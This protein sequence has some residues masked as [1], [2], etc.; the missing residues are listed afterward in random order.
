MNLFLRFALFTLLLIGAV[1][2]SF[3]QDETPTDTTATSNKIVKVELYNG[4]IHVGELLED[5]GREILIASDKVGK[6]Y[7]KKSDIAELTEIKREDSLLRG[8]FRDS[9]PFTTRYY[10]TNNALPFSKGDHYAMVHLYGPEIHFSLSDNFSL[11][12]MTTWIASPLGLAAKYSFKSPYE[13]VNFSVGTIL[14]SSGY[15]MQAQGWGGLH[16]GT[17][18]FGRP[19]KNVSLSSGFGYVDLV[20]N[21]RSNNEVGLQQ[22]NRGSISSIAALLPFGEKASFIFDSML[23]ISEKRIYTG[24]YDYTT[25]NTTANTIIT[26][27]SGTQVAAV[28]MPGLRFQKNANRAFQIALGGV[29]AY[30]SI[31]FNNSANND[32]VRTFPIPMCSWFF[33]L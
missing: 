12:V 13:H 6:L 24:I 15:L 11:G 30:S 14:F 33:T 32:N 4:V 21:D 2:F 28:L 20:E 1:N 7:I 31:G 25:D 10:F 16:W 8:T 22:L 27:Q 19:G 18:T 26:Y 23:S 3:S 29:I 9:G 17:V 5:D